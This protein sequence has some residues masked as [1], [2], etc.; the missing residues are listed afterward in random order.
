[1]HAF[2]KRISDTKETDDQDKCWAKD[3]HEFSYD[4]EDNIDDFMLHVEHESNSRTSGFKGF[5]DRCMNLLSTMN[6]RY[7]ITKKLQGLKRRVMEVS[8]RR[9]RYKIDVVVPNRNNTTITIFV[10]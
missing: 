9:T 8:E 10:Y 5:I 2:L 7:E 1:M 4:I 3:I 6:T